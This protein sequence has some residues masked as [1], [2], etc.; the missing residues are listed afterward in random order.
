MKNL[1]SVIVPVYNAEKY[2]QFCMD[3]I[4]RQTYHHLEIILID[5][6]ST[7]QS[8]KICDQYSKN[9]E[10]VT[11]YH[12]K[13][14]GLGLSRNFGIRHCHGSYLMFVDA[15]DFIAPHMIENLLRACIRQQA[16]LCITGYYQTSANGRIIS[17]ER[18]RN[19]IFEGARIKNELLPRMIGGLPGQWDGIYS[20]VWGKLYSADSLKKNGVFFQSE[21]K[22]QAEDLAFHL[23]YLPYVRRAAVIEKCDYYYRKNASSL[24]MKYKKTRYEET[25][26]FY[27]FVL[28]KIRLLKLDDESTKRANGMLLSHVLGCFRQELPR[29]S[30]HT[31][32]QCCQRTR[33]IVRSHTLQSVLR[34]YPVKQLPVKQRLYCECLKHRQ[35]LL[36]VAALEALERKTDIEA[37][38]RGDW[39]S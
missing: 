34:S 23:E 25:V 2:L 24:T 10:R 36:L 39:L 1:V 18:Y 15:D 37:F 26:T 38:F 32:R 6:G 35:T 7:D 29:Y 11:V 17:C 14:E 21:R 5:D 33:R 13:N 28:N 30:S 3:S 27:F 4:I 20:M 16:D 22:V 12:K 31:Y 19:E 9:D 8:G